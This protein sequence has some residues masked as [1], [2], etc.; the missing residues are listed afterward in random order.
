M[1]NI[2][3]GFTL[4]QLLVVIGIVGILTRLAW[5]GY[6]KQLQMAQLYQAQ[7][8][9]IE[10]AHFMHRHYRQFASFKVNSQ[11]WPTLPIIETPHYCIKL[12]GHPRG[13][14]DDEFTIKAVPK[15]PTQSSNILFI[16]QNLGVKLCQSSLNHCD[17]GLFFPNPARADEECTAFP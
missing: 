14:H 16:D 4:I 5:S 7:I 11:Q 10:N 3:R 15:S 12:Q 8:A 6:Q 17:E 13:L 9:L 1:M 2:P